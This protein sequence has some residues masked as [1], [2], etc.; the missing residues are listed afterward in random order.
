MRISLKLR[1]AEL[2]QSLGIFTAP[3]AE[4]PSKIVALIPKHIDDNEKQ[5]VQLLLASPDLLKAAE[6]LLEYVDP[7]LDGDQEY[8]MAVVELKR[9]CLF[10][11]RSLDLDSVL[12]REQFFDTPLKQ[13]S[14]H[15]KGEK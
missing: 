4:R 8:N 9:A 6:N 2:S 13:L 15:E 3:S 14:K 5:Y 11:R 10:A 12:F 1:L 7:H